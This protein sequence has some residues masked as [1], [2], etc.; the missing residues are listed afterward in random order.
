MFYHSIALLIQ[1]CNTVSHKLIG[2]RILISLPYNKRSIF[3]K[4]NKII[5]LLKK[6]GRKKK[7][8]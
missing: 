1:T 4:S 2:E 8:N 7:N 5:M 6:W 3:K